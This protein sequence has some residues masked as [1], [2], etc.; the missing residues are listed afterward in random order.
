MAM[1]SMQSLVLAGLIAA[2]S[3][4][5]GTTS[6][7]RSWDVRFGP[8]IANELIVGRVVSER[9]VWI[10]TGADALVRVDLDRGRYTRSSL[11]PLGD[12]EHV[13]GLA[14]T[15][16]DEMW[17]LIGRGTLARFTEDGTIQRRIPLREPHVGV[18]GSGRELVYQVM[19]FEPPADALTT[20]PPGGERRRTW[21]GMRTRALPLARGAVAA[22]NLVSCGATAGRSIP[23]WFPDQA[24]VT[25]ADASGISR[26][27][28][29]EGLPVVAPEIL[30]ASENPRRPVRDA[31]VSATEDLWVLG[32][33]EPPE[34][35]VP[36][37]P[38]G[39]LLARYDAGGRLFRRVRLPEP[40]RLVLGAIGDR[41]LLLSWDGQVVE[42]RP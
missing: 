24:A 26:E 21:S 30:L 34:T 23:C 40:A 14:S 4:C 35:D 27:I 16:R 18:F 39:W 13:W 3:G 20:G 6:G 29:L 32:S 28:P 9:T 10:A 19:N 11:H 1:R 7:T 2:L 37:R 36:P 15:G 42:V 25:L 41:C 33:G 38:G 12:G 22:L 5:A 8:V 31:F 17:T